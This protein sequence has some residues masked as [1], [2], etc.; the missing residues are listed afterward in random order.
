MAFCIRKKETK[1]EIQEKEAGETKFEEAAED[2]YGVT[3]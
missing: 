3:A 2:K 1:V